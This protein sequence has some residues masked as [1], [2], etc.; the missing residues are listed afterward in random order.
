MR[1]LYHIDESYPLIIKKSEKVTNIPYEKNIQYEIYEPFNKTKLNLSICSNATADIYIP[2]E[3]SENT[4]KKYDSLKKVGYDLFNINDPFYLKICT[5]Y[6]TENGTDVLLEDRKNDYYYSSVNEATCQGNCQNSRYL[7]DSK[8][9]KCECNIS[10]SDINNTDYKKF[11]PKQFYNAFYDILK[12]SNYKVL[13]CYNLAFHIDSIT[14]N[15]GSIIVIVLY[16]FYL[17]AFFTYVKNGITPLKVDMMKRIFEKPMKDKI[18]N[19]NDDKPKICNYINSSART[20]VLLLNSK[21]N[22]KVNNFNNNKLNIKSNNKKDL[23][24]LKPKNIDIINNKYN[25]PNKKKPSIIII[26]EQKLK[27]RKSK[28]IQKNSVRNSKLN[29]NRTN[30]IKNNNNIIIKNMNFI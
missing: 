12:Y 3:L 24:N 7:S 25:P 2:I 10:D 1:R 18:I 13:R 28:L 19:Y 29:T 6:K 30:N 27:Q 22:K 21:F 23:F 17:V 26:N 16:I 15:Y 11:Y 5:P 4:Q 9:L 20:N 8:L 14:I